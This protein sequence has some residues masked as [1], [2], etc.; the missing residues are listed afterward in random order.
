MRPGRLD[1]HIHVPVPDAEGRE[2]VIEVHT[3][4]KPLADDV[5]IDYV[6][7]QTEGYVGADIEALFREAALISTRDLIRGASHQDELETTTT[8]ITM[9]HIN[10]ALEEVG[11][12]VTKDV[13]EQYEEIEETFQ[14]ASIE[15]EEDSRPSRTFQ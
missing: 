12:S 4:D 13:R 9:D 2:K 8:E 5:D 11:P 10:A 3:Q 6:A 15:E 7:Q 1:R 14:K